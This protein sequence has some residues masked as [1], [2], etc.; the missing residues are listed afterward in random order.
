MMICVQTYSPGRQRVRIF[1]SFYAVFVSYYAVFVLKMIDLQGASMDYG[2]ALLEVGLP[3]MSGLQHQGQTLA[4]GP[5]DGQ[6]GAC[7]DAW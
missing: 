6:N 7:L 2:L 1:V 3:S 5:A 4:V